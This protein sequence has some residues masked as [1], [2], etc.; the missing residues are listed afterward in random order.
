MVKMVYD[1]S[2]L[3]M[4]DLTYIPPQE[5]LAPMTMMRTG[6]DL[7]VKDVAVNEHTSPLVG[8]RMAS[9]HNKRPA[10]PLNI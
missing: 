1:K 5:L 3:G 6:P 8:Q 10:H 2:V 7:F 9:L 4:S